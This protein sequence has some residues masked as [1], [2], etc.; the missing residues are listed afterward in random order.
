MPND[1]AMKW[2]NQSKD[3][4][5]TLFVFEVDQH[6]SHHLTHNEQTRHY[7]IIHL[8]TTEA[9]NKCPTKYDNWWVRDIDLCWLW[10]SVSLHPH[11][12]YQWS[13][14]VDWKGKH[15]VVMIRCRTTCSQRFRS[16]TTHSSS[17]THWKLSKM[18]LLQ[19]ENLRT[20][21]RE[22]NSMTTRFVQLLLKTASLI[23]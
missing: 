14:S 9:T 18:N 11:P 3:S 20:I 5:K 22:Q 1:T 21:F 7:S 16:H 6:L 8:W 2:I 15:R 13:T 10:S 17:K 12:Q 23:I 4:K 19:K